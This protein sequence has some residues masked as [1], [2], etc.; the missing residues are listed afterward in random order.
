[1]ARHVAA[2]PAAIARARGLVKV[3]GTGETAVRALDGV[4]VDL[5]GPG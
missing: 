3:Y 1:M 2:Q 5:P 4:D